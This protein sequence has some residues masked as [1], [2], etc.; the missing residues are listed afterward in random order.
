MSAAEILRDY[1]KNQLSSNIL[2]N[3]RKIS[4]GSQKFSFD[5][6][7]PFTGI[8]LISLYIY[9]KHRNNK[10]KVFSEFQRLS[11]P[12]VQP[13]GAL[14]KQINEFLNSSAK[15]NTSTTSNHTSASQKSGSNRNDPPTVTIPLFHLTYLLKNIYLLNFRGHQQITISHLMTSLKKY[16]LR[17]FNFFSILLIN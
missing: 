16:S 14:A 11:L 3:E 1:H 10:K 7:T 8:N 5:E 13:G 15:P 17:F 6:E 4:F 2:Q 9:A 12:I